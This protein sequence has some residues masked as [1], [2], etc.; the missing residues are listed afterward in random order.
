MTEPIVSWLNSSRSYQEGVKLYLEHGTN[1]LL[2][3]C[4]LEPIE[5]EFKRKKLVEALRGLLEQSREEKTIVAQTET[6][7][8]STGK[9]WPQNTKDQILQ[10][11]RE[12]WRPLYGE[13]TTLQG[14]IHEVAMQ[15]K[16]DPSKKEEA[17]LMA[18]RILELDDEIMGIYAEKEYYLKHGSLPVPVKQIEEDISTEEAYRKKSNLERYLRDLAG[19]LDRAEISDHKRTK[20][21]AKW[22][23]LSAQ[24][25]ELNKKLK[26]AP[27]EG[28]PERG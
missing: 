25:I 4:F 20:W 13:M 9:Q 22:N 19:K 14:R 3:N 8:A 10:S 2:R 15:A 12:R 11:L 26:R 21:L 16:R 24:L 6:V 28:I 27:N 23:A 7:Y 17:R 18:K 5:T 1:R